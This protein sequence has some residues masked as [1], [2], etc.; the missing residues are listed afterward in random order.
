MYLFSRRA[1]IAP[2]RPGRPSRATGITEKVNQITD[3]NVALYAQTYSPEVGV[4]AGAP[5]SPISRRSK[6]LP[7][8]CSSTMRTPQCSTLAHSSG[9]SCRRCAVAT[10]LRRTRPDS[11]DRIRQHRR[12]SV[13]DR[14]RDAESS[15]AS[16]SQQRR[17]RPRAF[18]CC[19][20]RRTGAYGGV[21]WFT[22]YADVAGAGASP[23]GTRVDSK[24][25]ESS[26]TRCAWRLHRRRRKTRQLIYR[27]LT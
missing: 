5:S 19:P 17:R 15:S 25:G 8:N 26:S 2:G 12:D 14:K 6:P 23:A 22:A 4:L 27:R 13:L 21:G 10:R 18:R 20:H 9:L 16:T 11:V 7:T 24:F 1:R 3:L